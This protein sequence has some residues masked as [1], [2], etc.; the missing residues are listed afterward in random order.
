MNHIMLLGRLTADPEI[1]QGQNSQFTTFTLA[2]NNGKQ[3]EASF[4]DCIAFGENAQHIQASCKKGHRLLV[5]GRMQQRKW[6]AQDGT[7]RTSWNLLVSLF[8]F[9]EPR[10]NTA[11][12]PIASASQY[13]Y[14]PMPPGQYPSQIPAPYPYSQQQQQSAMPPA[15]PQAP[16]QAVPQATTPQQGRL[17]AGPW[18]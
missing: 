12:P 16:V 4:F 14:P 9:I 8:Q 13:P 18:A 5:I 1:H 7:N 3:N 6:Q 2:D 10:Q 17:P 11:V 15:M